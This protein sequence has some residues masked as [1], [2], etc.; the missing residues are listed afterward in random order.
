MVDSDP[1]ELENQCT[2]RESGEGKV[3]SAGGCDCD[4]GIDGSNI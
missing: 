2:G 4:G 3:E 1:S